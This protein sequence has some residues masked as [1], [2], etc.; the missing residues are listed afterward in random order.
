MTEKDRPETHDV[1][2]DKNG[3]RCGKCPCAEFPD[4]YVPPAIPP[5]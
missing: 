5:E 2:C 3:C 4:C 1:W